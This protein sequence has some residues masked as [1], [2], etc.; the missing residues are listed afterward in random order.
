MTSDAS[1]TKAKRQRKK[2]DISVAGEGFLKPCPDSRD[3]GVTKD[4]A[5]QHLMMNHCALYH[6]L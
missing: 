5:T 4:F 3:C 2:T 1:S 6:D